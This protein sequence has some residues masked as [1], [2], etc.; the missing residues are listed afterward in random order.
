MALSAFTATSNPADEAF[1]AAMRRRLQ[2]QVES[3]RLRASQGAGRALNRRGLYGEGTT[4]A[5]AVSGIGGQSVQALQQGESQIQQMDFQKRLQEYLIRLQQPSWLERGLGVVGG[6]LG[7]FLG[8]YGGTLGNRVAGGS[9]DV[10]ISTP[11]FSSF[12]FP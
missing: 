10:T 4:L 3:Q 11:A 7:S 9:G 12:M 5:G 8:G 6:G 2:D 1:F